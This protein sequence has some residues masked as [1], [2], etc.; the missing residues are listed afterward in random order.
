MSYLHAAV[1]KYKRGYLIVCNDI[2]LV[3]MTCTVYVCYCH[4]V[5]YYSG[6]KVCIYNYTLRNAKRAAWY[7]VLHKLL[8][9]IKREV[10]NNM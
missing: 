6:D 2:F 4:T 5:M 7:L 3:C 10:Y 8:C 9:F 1:R